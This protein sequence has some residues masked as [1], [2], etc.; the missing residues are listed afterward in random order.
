MRKSTCLHP[1]R[2]AVLAALLLTGGVAAADAVAFRYYEDAISRF[3]DGDLKGAEIQLR[4]ALQSDPGQLP[5]RILMGRL[6]LALGNPLQAENE[7]SLALKLGADPTLTALPLA[8]ARQELGKHQAIIDSLR[9]NEYPLALQPDLWVELG[10]ARLGHKDPVGAEIAYAEALKLA[11]GHTQ[12]LLGQAR[13][14]LQQQKYAE[15]APLIADVL[16]HSPGSVEAWFLMGT[17]N[18]ARGEFALAAQHFRQATSLDP[19]HEKAALGEAM[20]LL[21]GGQPQPAADLLDQ[22]R[23]ARPT[24]VEAHYLY[25]QALRKLGRAAEAKE[26]MRRASDLVNQTAPADLGDNTTLLMLAAMVTFE[27]AEYGSSYGFL[28]RYLSYKPEDLAANLQLATLLLRMGKVVEASRLLTRLA[29]T[30]PDDPQILVMLGDVNNLLHDYAAAER[31]YQSALE[32]IEND[33][34]LISRIGLSQ[35]EQGR[36]DQAIETFRRLVEQDPAGSGGSSV[37]LGILYLSEGRLDAARAVADQV[38]ELQP[39]NLVALNLQAAVAVAQGDQ[40]TGRRL[41][42]ALLAKAP[43]FH[44]ARINLIKLDLLQGNT[45]SAAAALALLLQANPEDPF[46]LQEAARLALARSDR[47]AA[48]QHLERIRQRNP[49]AVRPILELA[50]LYIADAR[51]TDALQLVEALKRLLPENLLVLKGLA[52]VHLARGEV[53]AERNVL[54]DATRLAGFNADQLIGIARLQARAG[55]LPAAEHNLRLALKESP[56][57]SAAQLELGALFARQRQFSPA[58]AQV[59]EVL[60]RDPD[61]LAAYTLLAD[62]QLAQNLPEEAIALYRQALTRSEQPE[63][64]VSLYRALVLAGRADE[65]LAALGAWDEVHPDQVPVLRALAEHLE[66]SGDPAG[67]RD[68]YARL[69]RLRPYDAAIHNNL[70]NLLLQVDGERALRAAQRAY[71]LDPHN[72][73]I[74]DTLGWSLV[75][76]GELEPGLTHLRDALARNSRVPTIRYHLAVALEE[77]GSPDESA[78]ELQ[79]ALDMREPFPERDLAEQRL[80]RLRQGR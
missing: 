13:V 63:L 2:S 10:K 70:A 74:L 52:E 26:A 65:A 58:A 80:H 76:L 4:N 78:R 79:R 37:F 45:D 7:L 47:G 41:L 53:A 71:E 72:P 3:N 49:Q 69:A 20:A 6:Q 39:D 75:Q 29:A 30:T 46:A 36:T 66:R 15:A 16:A 54:T 42:E 38:V 27:S 5:A 55:D 40:A 8:Q 19:A 51:A 9:P 64:M 31:Y 48:I 77:Y 28:N 24:A 68:V 34:G 23:T 56:L 35:L 25:A 17:L 1:L 73:A 59:T 44:P 32:Q 50:R 57:S 22:I 67:A 21:D 14:L 43:G 18:Q 60:A 11:P 61:N 62:I 12:A 33:P